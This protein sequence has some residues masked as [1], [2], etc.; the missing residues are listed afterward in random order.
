MPHHILIIDDQTNL[1]RLIEME[2]SAEGYQVSLNWE[3]QPERSILTELNPDLVV[4]NW[5]LRHTSGSTI[6]Q[7]LQSL[8]PNL[9]IVI[10]T[11]KDESSCALTLDQATVVYLTKPFSMSNLLTAVKS[12][13]TNN[14]QSTEPTACH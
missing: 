9:P 3:N 4:L 13:L 7:R 1:Q 14:S 12:C 2:L 11:T 5:D 6:Y 10:I 8:K